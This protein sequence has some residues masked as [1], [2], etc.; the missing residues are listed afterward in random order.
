VAQV[1]EYLALQ[2][3]GPVLQF[4]DHH[5]LLL[6]CLIYNKAMAKMTVSGV[7]QI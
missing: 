2:A 7:V 1:L 3:Q 5:R 6:Q 4:Q